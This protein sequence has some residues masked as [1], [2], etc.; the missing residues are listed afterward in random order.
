MTEAK[1]SPLKVKHLYT[2][3]IK[4]IRGLS[5]PA[6][7]ISPLG[8]SH[9]R[10][11]MLIAME[12]IDPKTNLPS[13]MH[14][15][16]FEEMCLFTT[17]LPDGNDDNP[18]MTAEQIAALTEIEV[19]YAKDHC[20]KDT[21]KKVSMEAL[22]VPLS[23]GTEDLQTVKVRM[24]GSPT[25]AYDMGA[26]YNGWFSERFGYEVK[27]LYL[28]EHRRKVL[29]NV[30]PAVAA[31]QARGEM[32]QYDGL[33][34]LP[35]G[36]GDGSGGWWS[37]ISSAVARMAAN[38]PGAAAAG[39]NGNEG[40]GVDI[41]IGFADV[42]PFLVISTK[43][44]ENASSRLPDGQEMDITKFRPNIVVEGADEAFDEDYWGE[45]IFGGGKEAVRIILTQ[46]CARC[47]S[48]NVDF[49]TGKVGEGEDGK[50]L[51][52]LS[53]D[54]RVDPGSKWSPIFGRYGFLGGKG[55]AS[56]NVGD[57]VEVGKRNEARTSW[58]W[59]GLGT[60]PKQT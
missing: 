56:L 15:S 19:R 3:P 25:V 8:P 59:P 14:V 4:S 32:A 34:N 12:T 5:L 38:L 31:A 46:N 30:A 24:H 21:A 57:Q 47:N 17:H 52:L 18:S 2:Y 48:L 50:I 23:P 27:L 10:R 45:L 60:Y 26:K 58:E 43:S 28:G 9:D 40:E 36:E 39:L 51:K 35:E 6:L 41:G 11:F 49:R 1:T 7:P 37:G 13:N 42:A 53:K 33:K 44:W 55:E 16:K 29:G 22:R 20:F 54:R